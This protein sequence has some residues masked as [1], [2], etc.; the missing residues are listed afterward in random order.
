MRLISW[1]TLAVL[2]FAGLSVGQINLSDAGQDTQSRHGRRQR[3]DLAA[4]SEMQQPK[5]IPIV[6]SL[7]FNEIPTVACASGT[8]F[9]FRNEAS[10]QVDEAQPNSTL[11]AV[12]CAALP[13][14]TQLLT[15]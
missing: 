2:L 6:N 5:P 4:R 14:E 15:K 10:Q 9:A 3:P 13:K 1:V 7:R 8:P 12:D 11:R